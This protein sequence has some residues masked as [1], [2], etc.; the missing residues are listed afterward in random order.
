[1][2]LTYV[3]SI[4]QANLFTYNSFEE[5]SARRSYQH[6]LIIQ[7]FIIMSFSINRFL[8]L[9]LILGFVRADGAIYI[10]RDRNINFDRSLVTSNQFTHDRQTFTRT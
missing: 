6:I 7:L 10:N 4:K 5:P 3:N 1:M 2:S 9:I 8:F